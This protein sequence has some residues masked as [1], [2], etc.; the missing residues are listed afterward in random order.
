MALVNM[1]KKITKHKSRQFIV[2]ME[3]L[4][5]EGSGV[6]RRY[7]TVLMQYVRSVSKRGGGMKRR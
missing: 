7:I 1:Y 2:L 6:K 5:R 3:W 4:V